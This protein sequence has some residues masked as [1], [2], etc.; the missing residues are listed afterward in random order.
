MLVDSHCHLDY[1]ALKDREGVLARARSAGVVRIVNIGT[2]R[3]EF[4]AVQATAQA[5][6]EVYC[7][8]GV[9]PHHVHEDGENLSEDDIA[10]GGRGEKV[11]GIGE[12]GLDYYYN[13]AP[14][15]IQQESF[16]RHIRA[17]MK[18]DLPIVVHSREAEEDT[19]R[20]LREE[21]TGGGKPRGVMHCFSSKR[22]L[23]EEALDIGF[24]ISLSGILT[25]KKS[26]ELRAIVRDVPLDRL[27]VETDSPYLAPEPFRGK[28]CEPAHVVHT[29]RV[30]AQVKGVTEEEIARR[31]TENFFR[32]FDKVS[33]P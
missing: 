1:P 12:T 27:L 30:L 19:I 21:A 13:H 31:T 17:A 25:F 23:A 3:R 22:I 15:E 11:V 2:T 32:L 29:A 26:E 5:I 9:H 16:L 20:I 7:T 18:L 8:F 10:A 33:R 24:Y 14:R 28:P 6:P 4:G